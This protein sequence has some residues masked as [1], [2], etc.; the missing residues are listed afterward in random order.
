MKRLLIVLL[1]LLPL[2]SAHAE[3]SGGLT[4]LELDTPTVIE[5]VPCKSEALLFPDGR[6]EG[7][8]LSRDAEVAGHVFPQGSWPY[9][10]PP[11][12]LKCVFLARDFEVQGYLL[13]GKGHDFQTCFHPNGWL[14]FGNLREPLVI[15]G[16]PCG[17]ST[18]WKWLLKGPSG[19]QFHDNGRLKG[20]RL[21]RDVNNLKK[22]Q[23]IKIDREGNVVNV[24]LP[25]ESEK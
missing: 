10:D 17:A 24:V 8:L 25:E 11:G 23:W 6:L 16:V 4:K 5:G 14:A 3:P 22:D 1:V 20:C 9:F 15:Q 21:S 7:C 19:I 12:V 2:P 18:F 13:R